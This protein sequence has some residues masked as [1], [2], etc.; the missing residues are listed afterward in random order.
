MSN[1]LQNKT[2]VIALAVIALLCVAGSFVDWPKRT[3][4]PTAARTLSSVPAAPEEIFD[5][6]A[7]PAILQQLA[8]SRD[9]FAEH[10]SRPDPFSWP[11]KQETNSTN[12]GPVP[13][14]ALRAISIDAGK[15][16]AVLNQRVVAIG[17]KVG[18]YTVDQILPTEVWLRGPAGRIAVRLAR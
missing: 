6:P 13:S 10:T 8:T 1:P 7:R 17:D 16:F 14:F 9:L 5:I 12:A 15:A 18:D 4:I 11:R 2:V 3:L